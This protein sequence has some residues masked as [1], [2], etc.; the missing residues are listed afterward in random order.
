[1][2]KNIFILLLIG[3]SHQLTAQAQLKFT[4]TKKSFG[5]VKKGEQVKLSYEFTNTGNQP[6]VIIDAKAECSCTKVTW[7]KEPI[8]PGKS[9]NIE[10]LFDTSPTYDRQ[11]REVEVF[12]NDAKSPQK[13]RFKGVV[14][15]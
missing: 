14:L 6:L 5:F 4:D 1:M 2:I 12:S 7:P 3:L 9:N 8:L 15:K 11:D 13:I 10:V